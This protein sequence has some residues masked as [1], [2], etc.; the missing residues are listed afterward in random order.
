MSNDASAADLLLSPDSCLPATCG[1]TSTQCGER[2][3]GCGQR[4][5]CGSCALPQSCG[6]AGVFG[7]CGSAQ[8]TQWTAPRLHLDFAAA[9]GPQNS[10]YALARIWH[11]GPSSA[12]KG[13]GLYRRQ[14]AGQIDYNE[15]FSS[16]N[17]APLDLA[18]AANGDVHALYQDYSSGAGVV[19]LRV[20]VAGSIS[21]LTVGAENLCALDVDASGAAHIA[22][23]NTTHGLRYSRARGTVWE[24]RNVVVHGAKSR[25]AARALKVDG[26][27]VHILYEDSG[28]LTL[29]YALFDG[30]TWSYRRVDRSDGPFD[31]LR[32]YDLAIDQQGRPQIAWTIRGTVGEVIYTKQTQSGAWRSES[33]LRVNGS[34]LTWIS[35]D[36]DQQ[37]RPHISLVDFGRKLIVYGRR[38]LP[39]WLFQYPA[40]TTSGDSGIVLSGSTPLVFINPGHELKLLTP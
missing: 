5:W 19:Y 39:G 25:S 32:A 14:Q 28:N 18:V 1:G 10:A 6:G 17:Y 9:R 29:W 3:D 24:L 11:V 15:L 2:D 7:Q 27:R 34:L 16:G 36:L 37:D 33:V 40:A 23:G 31:G 35:L 26:Q 13:L 21:Q 30:S 12:G 4:I 22:C 38:D 20:T 8:W